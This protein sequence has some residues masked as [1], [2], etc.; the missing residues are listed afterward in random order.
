MM[1]KDL[2]TTVQA[3]AIQTHEIFQ[4]LVNAG[5]TREEAL[6][7]LLSQLGD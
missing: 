1:D 5:F 6:A 2:P 3:A 4:S 7:I